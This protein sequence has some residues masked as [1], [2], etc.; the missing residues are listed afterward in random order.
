MP[1]GKGQLF[2]QSVPYLILLF[3]DNGCTQLIDGG[4]PVAASSE[5]I[6]FKINWKET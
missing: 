2:W 6:F 4:I 3:Q 1:R 5:G